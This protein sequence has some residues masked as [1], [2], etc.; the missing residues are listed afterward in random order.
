MRVRLLGTGA[1][2]G[3]PQWNCNCQNC[4]GVRTGALQALP[5]T[6]SSVAI[7]PDSRRWFLLNASPDVRIQIESF[8][9]LLPDLDRIRGTAVEGVLLT[10]ADLD[11]VLGLLILREGFRLHVCA[12]ARVRQAL[13]QGLDLDSVLEHY[14]GVSW[15][16][17][18]LEISPLLDVDGK[19]TGLL[20]C[21]VPVRGKPP[22]YMVQG[23][24][25]GDVIGYRFVDESTGGRLLFMP[26]VAALDDSTLEE[27]RNCDA[28]LID[29][30]FWSENEM[31]QMGVGE[32]SASRMGHLPVGGPDGS[33]AK[34]TSLPTPHK[35]YIHIN[36]TNPMLIQ[37]SVECAAVE[38]AGVQIG[39]DGME[40]T[41]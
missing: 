30:T 20:Y 29:G 21:A 11:H 18:P 17:P 3:F 39:W 41:L 15:R 35:I 36:N 1:G 19:T 10:N 14:C 40:L 31:L 25:S 2:G 7:S 22:R 4:R 37:H 6:Q 8:A 27:M 28:L 16:E 26:D 9:P 33:L 5:R 24:S 12:T 34:I 13:S 38:A 23:A 32:D